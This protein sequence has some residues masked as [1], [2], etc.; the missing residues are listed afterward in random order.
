MGRS[1]RLLFN[2]TLIQDLN[3]NNDWRHMRGSLNLIR[4]SSADNFLI[5]LV[6]TGASNVRLHR[7][8]QTC[9]QN[10]IFCGNRVAKKRVTTRLPQ[11]VHDDTSTTKK[12]IWRHLCGNGDLSTTKFE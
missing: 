7:L 8:P 11:N 9:R 3:F 10:I 5:A 2:S 6:L 1:D 4:L 12:L